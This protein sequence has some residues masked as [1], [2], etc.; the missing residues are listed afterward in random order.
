MIWE[1][2]RRNLQLIIKKHG[3]IIVSSFILL[4]VAMV[5]REPFY[6]IF[7]EENY[8]TVHFVMEFLI[9]TTALTIATAGELPRCFLWFRYIF[10]DFSAFKEFYELV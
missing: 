7:G 1:S 4:I 8:V 3:L 10:K 9:I 6:G 5:F 2:P